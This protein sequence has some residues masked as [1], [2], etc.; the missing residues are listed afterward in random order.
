MS[1]FLW[2]AIFALA[3]LAC[4]E[5]AAG[6]SGYGAP[7]AEVAKDAAPAPAAAPAPSPAPA[8]LV[9]PAT[10]VPSAVPAAGSLE[11]YVPEDPPP[12]VDTS[13]ASVPLSDVVFDTF[14]GGFI[15]LSE[16][17]EQAIE[18]LRDAIKPVYVPK[19][20]PVDG[21]RWLADDD[22]V[23]GYVSESDAFAYPIK[24]LDL[25]EIVH[26]VIDGVP[27]LVTYCPLCGSGVVYDRELDGDTLV[28]GNT[29]ALYE[30]DMVMYDHQTGSYWFQVMGEAIVGPLTGKRLKPL[31][32]R[33]ATWTEWKK[34]HPDTKVLSRDLGLLRGGPAA[35]EIDSFTGYRETLNRGRF[36]FPVSE[37][38]LDGRLR[39]G[40]LVFAVDVNG[41]HRAYALGSDGARVINDEVGGQPVVVVTRPSGP[42]GLAYFSELDDRV[43]KFK[44]L[45]G[46]LVD[47]GTGSLWDDAGRAVAGPLAGSELTAVPS[48][49]S[50]WFSLAG[51]LPGLELSNP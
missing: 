23:L 47:E 32:S 12:T 40:D 46:A 50:F 26:D 22:L 17:S 14:R 6:G 16:A 18:A 51:A 44:L 24:M 42:S 4:T 11:L 27:V 48:R 21:V 25:H 43:L 13:L 37:D 28:F 35:Y 31:A 10:A 3:A 30:S 2:A 29:S 45:D 9:A 15:L 39:P 20:E 8:A 36:A 7:P 34:L 1:L 5:G 49:T 19:Y 41:R 38:K 33:T